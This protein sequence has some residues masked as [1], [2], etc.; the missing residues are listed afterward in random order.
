MFGADVTGV[1]P[2]PDRLPHGRGEGHHMRYTLKSLE[3]RYMGDD[4]GEYIIR[5][6]EEGY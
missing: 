4:I 1:G 2:R 5:V 6:Y 3:G